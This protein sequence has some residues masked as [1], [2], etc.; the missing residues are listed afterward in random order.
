MLPE[1]LCLV[2]PEQLCFPYWTSKIFSSDLVQ[3]ILFDIWRKT[4]LRHPLPLFAQAVN[5]TA[6]FVD[7]D[8]LLRS[9]IQKT[10]FHWD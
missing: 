1:Q 8:F 6:V 2:R 3:P 4:L 5:S 7:L 9:R 10:E